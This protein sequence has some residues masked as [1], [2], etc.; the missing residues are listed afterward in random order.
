MKNI[1]DVLNAGRH[2]KKGIHCDIRWPRVSGVFRLNEPRCP[3]NQPIQMAHLI[4]MFHTPGTGGHGGLSP[5]TLQHSPPLTS[6]S[7]PGTGSAARK[8]QHTAA[9]NVGYWKQ[10]L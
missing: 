8:R 7:S 1:L 6:R 3:S 2:V 10:R 9:T 5:N 4:A